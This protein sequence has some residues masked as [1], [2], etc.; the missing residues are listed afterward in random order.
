MNRWTIDQQAAIEAEVGPVLV[1]AAAGS[2]KT[3]VLV[4]RVLRRLTDPV[5]PIDL[6]RF[7]LVTFTNA[8]ASE[9]RAKLGSAMS[10]RLAAE[11]HNARLRRQVML[12]QKADITTMHSYCMKLVREHADSL[13]IP[14]DF[15]LLD[16]SESKQIR[17]EVLQAVLDAR[18]E[19]ADPA[20]L[21]LSDLLTGGQND[22]KLAAIILEADLK[23]GAHADPEDF[24]AFLRERLS[25]NEPIDESRIGQLL[26]DAAKERFAYGLSCFHKAVELLSEDP[27]GVVEQKLLPVFTQEYEKV[28]G[29]AA[30]LEQ[31]PWDALVRGIRELKESGFVPRLPP[32]A[33]MTEDPLKIEVTELRKTCKDV[34]GEIKDKLLIATAEETAF[35]RGLIGPALCAL[36]DTA[37]AFAEQYSAEKQR[38]HAADFTDLEHFAVRLLGKPGKPTALA[39]T[40]SDRYDEVLV[41]EYQDTNGVQDAI[42]SA[43]SDGGRKLF[44]V[45]DVKQSIYGFRLANP[46]LFLE[47][48]RSYA[49]DAPAGEPRRVILNQNFRS[50]PPVLDAVNAVMQKVMTERVG[51]LD[52]TAR[53]ALYPGLPDPAPKDP[54]YAVEV[55]LADTAVEKGEERYDQS[56]V[57]AEL[58]A[59]R[60]HRLLVE[61]LP[62]F[63]KAQGCTRPVEPGDIAILLRSPKR[64]A[65]ALRAALAK[66]GVSVR[67]EESTGLLAATEVGTIVS[68]LYIIDNP[69]QDIELIGVL[70]SPLFGFSEERLGEIR[71]KDKE[72]SFYDALTISAQTDAD[73]AAFLQTLN[74]LRLLAGDLPVY[75]L[76][77]EIYTRTGALGLFA[78]M[79][80]GAQRRRNLL[81]F[82]ERARAFEQNGTRGLYRFVN[83]LRGM[84]ENGDDFEIVRAQGGEGAVRILSI[85]KSKG[86]EYPVVI[87]TDCAAQFNHSDLSGSI[88]LDPKLGV[89]GKCRDLERGIQYDTLDRRAFIA[90]Q[91]Q[92]S[93]SEE[94]RVLYV[95]M[96]RARDKLI[97]TGVSDRMEARIGDCARMGSGDYLSPYLMARV[98]SFLEWILSALI[99]HPAAVR[100]RSA[101]GYP[102]VPD[103]NLPEQIAFSLRHASEI[104]ADTGEQ[105][106]AVVKWEAEEIPEV[107]EDVSVGNNIMIDLPAKLTATGMKTDFKSAEASEETVSQRPCPELRRP[108]FDRA[109]TGLTPAE[110]GTAHH[111]FLQFCD[112]DACGCGEIER[113]IVR[114]KEEHILAPEQADVIRSDRIARFF[115]SDLYR[116]FTEA[117]VRREFKFS[118][119]VPAQA[120]YTEVRDPEEKVLLQGVVD[121][122]L[123]TEEGFVVID[124][125]TDRVK[126]ETASVRALDYAPQLEAY[127]VAVEQIF[128]RPVIAKKLFF[129]ETGQTIDC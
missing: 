20:F 127:V 21:A 105:E 6:D 85:H 69:R 73:S 10:D 56:A 86:L 84:Q 60:I 65:S 92:A 109:K 7:L 4:E 80:G 3:A 112:F 88:L 47:R 82:L 120:Y 66:Y 121:C 103:P 94:L 62:I 45:G 44:M 70:R 40:L 19:E 87:L 74:D 50:R 5:H 107:P 46:F 123:E 42:F 12:L 23:I 93:I 104:L 95:G 81:A 52:Y 108:D 115:A 119:V 124:F 77:W 91:E 53:E 17:Q 14:A 38:R 128:G 8:A 29:F 16:E 18:Y 116:S 78:G 32:V 90:A 68:F 9:M 76:V 26:R 72:A 125:K 11:P 39:K 15:R 36:L 2:G 33:G 35:D 25:R 37:E 64:R 98:S 22:D 79:P 67:T 43:L 114:L 75:R 97:M 48:Y 102:V 34:V 122:L 24:C 51:D 117:K 58:V 83:L 49:D 59:Q 63:D 61:G 1:S 54:R 30:V 111:L 126:P 31:A 101:G 13:G 55:L 118:V 110:R 57:E 113:E 129:L 71:L 28:S 96:T 99:R 41:D 27:E 100:L 106:D 89:A